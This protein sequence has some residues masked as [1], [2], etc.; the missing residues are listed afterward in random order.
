MQSEELYIGVMSGTSLDGI[1]VVLTGFQ[2]GKVQIYA[3]YCH[4]IPAGI[5]QKI[6][7]ICTGQLTSLKSIGIL[8]HQLGHLFAQAVNQLLSQT[9]YQAGDIRAIG[10]HGQT[11]Y[12]HPDQCTPFTIQLGDAN[13]IAIETGIDTVADFRRKDMALGGQGAP[14]VPAFHQA[15][16]Q[17]RSHSTVVVLNI[18]GMANISVLRA[19][20]PVLGYDTGPGNVLIDSWC[21]N[22]TGMA[23]DQDASLAFSGQVQPELL[24][25]LE[26]D[27]YFSAPAP[28][29]TGR[30]YFNLD[31]VHRHLK[32]IHSRLKIEDVQRTLCQL[33]ANTI[34]SQI[35]QYKTGENPYVYVCGGGAHNPLIMDELA[36]KLTQWHITTTTEYGISS[37][38][39]EAIAFAWLARQRIHGLPGNIPEVTGASKAVSLGII[40][41]AT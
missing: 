6:L 36:K 20:H 2:N 28:K 8:D 13:I 25:I 10:C 22:H 3:G 7:D 23:F 39:M 26:S 33:T 32:G 35:S 16:F 30:E 18:G 41:S 5:R 12:H 17:S 38:L 19:G 9:S 37:D 34:S 4:P 14:L 31:W 29:S 1:D 24:A 27:P 11:V 21:H 40:Y 15:I